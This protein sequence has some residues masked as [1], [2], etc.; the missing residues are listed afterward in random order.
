MKRITIIRKAIGIVALASLLA[1]LTLVPAVGA[2]PS[3]SG[4]SA[5]IDKGMASVAQVQS[6][7]ELIRKP[8][9]PY[10]PGVCPYGYRFDPVSKQCVQIVPS[11]TPWPCPPGYYRDRVDRRCIPD[12][13][14]PLPVP[15]KM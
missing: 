6:Q 4:D 8:D 13:P 11:P 7:G 3:M 10:P 1:C 12:R 14:V 5:G 15:L 9:G 2:L